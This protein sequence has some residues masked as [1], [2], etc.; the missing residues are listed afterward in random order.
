MKDFQ[1]RFFFFEF[2]FFWSWLAAG[3]PAGL[4]GGGDK[5][6][7]FTIIECSFF[8]PCFS[9]IIEKYSLKIKKKNEKAENI[10]CSLFWPL[11]SI[12]I[13]KYSLKTQTKNAGS[14]K[15]VFFSICGPPKHAPTR[16]GALKKNI[17]MI[18]KNWIYFW[19]FLS[20]PFSLFFFNFFTIFLDET[21]KT[22]SEKGALIPK[23][24]S[25]HCFDPFF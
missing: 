22:K 3:W 1:L 7:R 19:V 5:S 12:F 14:I 20:A 21:E 2:G 13:E 6:P 9:R 24:L 17:V 8:D 10:E 25:A 23:I 4:P 16:A 18:L 11:F 15:I